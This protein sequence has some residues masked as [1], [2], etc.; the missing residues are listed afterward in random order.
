M[1]LRFSSLAAFAITSCICAGGLLCV[2]AAS[3]AQD[4]DTSAARAP[5]SVTGCGA[6]EGRKPTAN[7]RGTST[8][9][10][11][12]QTST[13]IAGSPPARPET[14]NLGSK[15]WFLWGTPATCSFPNR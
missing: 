8:L 2:R 1:T 13:H 9:D 11:E 3:A 6:G 4:S 15:S 12:Y 14:D 7:S 10:T 5:I